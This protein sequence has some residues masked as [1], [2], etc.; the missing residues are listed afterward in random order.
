MR[1]RLSVLVSCVAL[2]AMLAQ[3]VFAAPRSHVGCASD[4][5]ALSTAIAAADPG[6]RLVISG[7]C[8]GFLVLDKDL[9][10]VGDTPG[11]SLVGDLYQGVLAVSSGAVV[12]LSHLTVDS[13]AGSPGFVQVLNEGNLT[14]RDV[15]ISNGAI[16]AIRNTGTL[17]LFRSTIT[18]NR[19]KGDAPIYNAGGSVTLNQSRVTDNLNTEVRG[20]IRNGEGGTFTIMASFVSGN[21]GYMGNIRNEG[22]MSVVNSEVT[23]NA[24][25]APWGMLEN[26]GT[27]LVRGT[28]VAGNR[29]GQGGGIHNGGTMI[30]RDSSVVGNTA[31]NNGGGIYNAADGTADVIRTLIQGNTAGLDGGGIFNEGA[32]VLERVTLLDNT[33]ND[34]TGC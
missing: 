20:A 4:P 14:L 12:R 31:I 2:L 32:L 23:G 11:A 10:I 34:C 22:T 8:A 25:N 13:I 6:T 1:L 7:A 15:T 21:Y 27:L 29:G 9:T 16:N 33:P 24:G 5:E 28:I 30:L 3:P 17:T 18:A 19:G 26:I